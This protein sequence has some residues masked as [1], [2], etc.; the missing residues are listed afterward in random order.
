MMKLAETTSSP[1][2]IAVLQRAVEFEVVAVLLV[3][4]EE[5]GGAD[6]ALGRVVVGAEASWKRLK[7]GSG[8]SSPSGC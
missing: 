2:S 1:A 5:E 4:A 3:V 6:V 7:S 8:G